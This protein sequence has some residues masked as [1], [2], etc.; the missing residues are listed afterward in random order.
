MWPHKIVG[1]E[2]LD[3]SVPD[4]P[5]RSRLFALPPAGLG[6]DHVESLASYLV[7]LARAHAVSPRQLIR[8]EFVTAA[9]G[10]R[11]FRWAARHADDAGTI[12]GYGAYAEGFVSTTAKLTSVA[13]V[14]Y[15]TLL[16]LAGLLPS[17]S[18]GVIARRPKWCRECMKEMLKNH[19]EVAW[20][21]VWSL[22]LYRVCHRHNRFLAT[23]CAHC[24][25]AQHFIPTYPDLAHCMYCQAPLSE[26]YDSAA[27]VPT[28]ADIWTADAL[29]DVVARLCEL[30]GIATSERFVDYLKA[31]IQKVAGG[32]RADL[33]RR[34][35][36]PWWTAKN[37]L[38]RG[39]RPSLPAFLSVAHAIGVR[40]AEIFLSDE[41]ITK[42]V[43]PVAFEIRPRCRPTR[44]DA[45][46]RLRVAEA[47]ADILGDPGDTRSMAE[48]ARSLGLTCSILRYWFPREGVALC[49]KHSKAKAYA[50][51][52]RREAEYTLVADVVRAIAS[53]GEY[54]GRRKVNEALAELQL[55]LA[56]P[57]MLN[58]Y[59]DA[60]KQFWA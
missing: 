7:R 14:R 18:S 5:T 46:V 52:Q 36:L 45:T 20:P 13:T 26:G 43:A 2:P 10:S 11:R 24:G 54:P 56:Q 55:S 8:K 31:M 6:T 30:D 9:A 22:D 15:L 25:K 58:A 53:R 33:C 35:G 39:E 34:I 19:R 41:A 51:K 21:L 44:M 1:L 48:I 49:A 37:W 3:L 4:L 47:L 60:V 32:N 28:S 59:R 29:A 27:A 40:P 38:L 12:N 17:T 50:V 42:P 57:D 16:P 23:A